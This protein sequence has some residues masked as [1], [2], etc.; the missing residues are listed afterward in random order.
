VTESDYKSRRGKGIILVL[1]LFFFAFYL[2]NESY[3]TPDSVEYVTGIIEMKTVRKEH[4]WSLRRPKPDQY[5]FIFK[6]TGLNEYLGIFLGSGNDAI[7]EGNH[8]DKLFQVG[9]SIEVYY[10]NNF[11]TKSENLTRLIHKINYQ[12]ETVYRTNE[13][14]KLIPGFICLVFGFLA[15]GLL[16]WLKRKYEREKFAL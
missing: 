1:G 10:D 7:S 6:L 9:Q 12:G 11:V 2:I 8:Y 16:I 13:K 5:T 4:V 14:K 3:K 15:I